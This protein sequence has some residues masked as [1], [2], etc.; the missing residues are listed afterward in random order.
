MPKRI[1]DIILYSIPELSNKLDVT[2]NTLRAYI[3]QGRLKGQKMGNRWY[4]SGHS[5]KIFFEGVP[6]IK[7]ETK[8]TG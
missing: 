4:V 6:E 1:G 7:I 3:K 8:Q 2:P 5:L